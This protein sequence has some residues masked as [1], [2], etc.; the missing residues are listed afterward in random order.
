MALK[1]LILKRKIDDVTARLTALREK[2]N[3]FTTREA[4]LTA[5]VEI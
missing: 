2:D 1:A 3:S 5:A 4:E